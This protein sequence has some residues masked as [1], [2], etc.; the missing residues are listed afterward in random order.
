MKI[1]FV[2]ATIATAVSFSFAALAE[3]PSYQITVK[4]HQFSPSEVKVPA[5]E[6]FKLTVNN[7]DPSP[8]EFDSSDLGREKVVPGKTA[9]TILLGPLKPGT[10]RFVGEFNQKTAQGKIIAE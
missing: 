3:K 7:L 4:D 1:F 2:V 8:E 5:G 10:Y 6:K 9:A